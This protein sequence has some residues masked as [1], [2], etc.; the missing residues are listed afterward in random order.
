MEHTAQ[1]KLLAGIPKSIQKKTDPKAEDVITELIIGPWN[2]L[3]KAHVFADGRRVV[4]QQ[5]FA[6]M[7]GRGYVLRYDKVSGKASLLPIFFPEVS[8]EG[9]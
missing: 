8:R 4:F 7:K 2:G 6:M 9:E 5:M 3:L 1:D